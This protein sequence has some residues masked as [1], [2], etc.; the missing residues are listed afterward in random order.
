MGTTLLLGY[1]CHENFSPRTHLFDPKK[2]FTLKA[3]YPEQNFL[4]IEEAFDKAMSL[5]SSPVAKEPK[6]LDTSISSFQ[7]LIIHYA[8]QNT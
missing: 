6:G 7:Y 1:H 8:A 4:T 5:P 2:V 3:P